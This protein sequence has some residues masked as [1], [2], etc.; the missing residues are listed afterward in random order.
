M[1]IVDAALIGE[2][3]RR[4]EFLSGVILVLCPEE[5]RV[6]RLVQG[7]GLGVEEIRRRI[8]SQ[9]PPENKIAIADWVIE[10]K[11]TL[12]QLYTEVDR[13]ADELRS[14]DA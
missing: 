12:E 3:G 2:N 8:A 11:G 13:I 6:R 7:R 14:R 9:T 1:A 5:E 4:D 10:N